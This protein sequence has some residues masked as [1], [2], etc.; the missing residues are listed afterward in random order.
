MRIQNMRYKSILTRWQNIYHNLLHICQSHP[1]SPY[2]Q[3]WIKAIN[4]KERRHD[5]MTKDKITI[6]WGCSCEPESLFSYMRYLPP[7]RGKI[8]TLEWPGTTQTHDYFLPLLENNELD[9]RRPMPVHSMIIRE[10]KLQAQTAFNHKVLAYIKKYQTQLSDL[11]TSHQ[12]REIKRQNHKI[13]TEILSNLWNCLTDGEPNV[14]EAPARNGYLRAAIIEND[15][16]PEIALSY[17]AIDEKNPSVRM[18]YD[19]ADD[20]LTLSVWKKTLNEK[21]DMAINLFEDTPNRNVPITTT[22]GAP[23][24]AELPAPLNSQ[25]PNQYVSMLNICNNILKTAFSNRTILLLSHNWDSFVSLEQAAW[26]VHANLNK[27]VEYIELFTPSTAF[28]NLLGYLTAKYQYHVKKI[29]APALSQTLLLTICRESI[30]DADPM[31]KR[32]NNMFHRTRLWELPLP[33]VLYA[34]YGTHR[35]Y[36]VVGQPIDK[37]AEQIRTTYLFSAVLKPTTIDI[38]LFLTSLGYHINVC[39]IRELDPN[40]ERPKYIGEYVEIKDHIYGLPR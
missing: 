21:P 11:V 36:E 6:V 22:H 28:I 15:K 40:E 7:I 13:I 9:Y 31:I 35:T 17:V 32:I 16:T 30:T 1:K 14:I 37:T 10:T 27:D 5:T 24:I 8:A 34:L 12:D 23:I 33:I 20:T 19:Q 2:S 38:E 18:R 25:D 29:A 4:K 26:S 3:Q 39:A